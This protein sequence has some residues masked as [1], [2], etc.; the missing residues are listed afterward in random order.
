MVA[1]FFYVYPVT[2]VSTAKVS[3]YNFT[4]N[5]AQTSSRDFALLVWRDALSMGCGTAVANV[6]Q[7]PTCEVVVCWYDVPSYA[8]ST[9]A[10]STHVSP[11]A[12]PAGSCSDA[13]TVLAMH[14]A[15]R[16]ARQ[17]APLVWDAS[18]ASG[19][20]L[21]SSQ[22]AGG[23][24][25]ADSSVGDAAHVAGYGESVYAVSGGKWGNSTCNEAVTAWVGEGA[26]Y[27]DG[28]G[29]APS[30][31]SPAAVGHFTQAVWRATSRVGCGVATGTAAGGLP[32]KVVTCRYAV[33][34]NEWSDEALLK[35]VGQPGGAVALSPRGAVPR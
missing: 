5:T 7:G 29:G 12:G 34:G 19:A 22:L 1:G 9:Q 16:A 4:A 25:T 31:L 14:N 3:Q 33:P 13:A 21:W 26:A 18:L 8:V 17:A 24:C 28:T 10:Y 30:Q 2:C 32:C 27:D 11:P 20:G 23:K 6:T 35:Q 15:A